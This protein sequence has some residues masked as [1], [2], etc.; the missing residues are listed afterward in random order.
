MTDNQHDDRDPVL[1]AFQDYVARPKD[2]VRRRPDATDSDIPSG[3]GIECFS[4]QLGE[5]GPTRETES[6]VIAT[7]PIRSTAELKAMRARRREAHEND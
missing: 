1:A 2:I 3:L 7:A 5:D 6:W 4:D